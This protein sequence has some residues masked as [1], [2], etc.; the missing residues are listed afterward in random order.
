MDQ[1]QGLALSFDIGAQQAL[2]LGIEQSCPL[3]ESKGGL[4]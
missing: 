2:L 1:E 3:S 4:S